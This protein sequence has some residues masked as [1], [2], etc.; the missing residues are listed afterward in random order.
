MKTE[1]WDDSYGWPAEPKPRPSATPT[2]RVILPVTESIPLQQAAAAELPQH[3]LGLLSG[4]P[5]PGETVEDFLERCRA[6]MVPYRT[7]EQIADKLASIERSVRSFR[8]AYPT[9]PPLEIK[10]VQTTSERRPFKVVKCSKASPEQLSSEELTEA[11]RI[12]AELVKLYQVG[13]ISGPDDPE[14]LF[15][16]NLIR[17]ADASFTGHR[18]PVSDSES[19]KPAER[20]PCH[21]TKEQLVPIPLGLSKQQRREFLERDLREAIG[22]EWIEE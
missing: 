14:A 2:P 1:P 9:Q 17:Q 12:A 6:A 7:E 20:Q 22:E 10:P 5:E 8:G 11:R 15:Y 13:A 16:A 21:P 19:S 18:E 3:A 4:Y